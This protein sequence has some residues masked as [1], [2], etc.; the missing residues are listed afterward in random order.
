MN[1]LTVLLWQTSK[2]WYGVRAVLCSLPVQH[3][4]M[5]KT[6]YNHGRHPG[7][8]ASGPIYSCYIVV[9]ARYSRELV[10]AVRGPGLG[11]LVFITKGGPWYG[12]VMPSFC[13]EG[14]GESCYSFS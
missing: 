8:C 14:L 4:Q 6:R 11:H 10:I 5:G 3:L 1:G 9:H 13:S 2:E 12:V 7:S